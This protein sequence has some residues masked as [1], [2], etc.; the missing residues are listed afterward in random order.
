MKNIVRVPAWG[1]LFSCMC[2]DLV[3]HCENSS[4]LTTS[5]LILF[6]APYANDQEHH[7]HS[8]SAQA[9]EFPPTG[10]CEAWAIVMVDRM[11]PCFP[12][13]PI[14]SRLASKLQ[15]QK[16]QNQYRWNIQKDGQLRRNQNTKWG[17]IFRKN[18]VHCSLGAQRLVESMLM[19]NEGC[20]GE[21]LTFMLF[22]SCKK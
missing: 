14:M 13:G 4:P 7:F 8:V 1:S 5:D 10:G 20:F 3:M 6:P 18:R 22:F 9:A 16:C 21:L 12:A 19:D 17:I 11:L 15:L 2:P